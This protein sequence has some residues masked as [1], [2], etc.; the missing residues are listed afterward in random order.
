MRNVWRCSM[1]W[2]TGARFFFGF[3]RLFTYSC[4]SILKNFLLHPVLSPCPTFWVLNALR[5]V[6]TPS[7]SPNAP[8][9]DSTTSMIFEANVSYHPDWFEFSDRMK[10]WRNTIALVTNLIRSSLFMFFS[11]HSTSFHRLRNITFSSEKRDNFCTFFF[12]SHLNDSNFFLD[13]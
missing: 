12:V 6:Q 2:V 5:S 1:T 3:L 7:R 8:Q 11:P 13:T 9:V 10:Y 4:F